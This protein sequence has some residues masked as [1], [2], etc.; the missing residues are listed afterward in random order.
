MSYPSGPQY[1]VKYTLTGPDGA[2]AVFNDDTSPYYVGVLSSD[3]SGLDSADVRENAADMVEFDGGIHGNF[4]YGRRPVVLSGTILATSATDRN[5]KVA[6]LQRASNAMRGDAT[7]VWQ[8]E[9]GLEQFVKLRR[10]QPLRVT[11]PF[12][13]A[14]QLAMVAADPRIYGSTLTSVSVDAAGDPSAGRT[15]SK[16]YD[17]GYGIG[18]SVGQALITNNGNGESPPVIRI[19]GPGVNPTLYSATTDESIVLT[20]TLGA[21][22]YL[23]LDLSARTVRLNGDTNRYGAINFPSTS[24]WLLQPDQNDIRLG[25][26]SFTAGA[27]MV[28][29]YRDAWI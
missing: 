27:R 17:F 25:Y 7:L 14:F 24:W 10:Q 23:E 9:G 1:G 15:Y 28:I 8:P 22:D 2:Q 11:G 16:T 6:K 5:T 20:Y 3:S 26:F 21:G 18:L 29:D 4:Y 19:Y 12:V 13:K